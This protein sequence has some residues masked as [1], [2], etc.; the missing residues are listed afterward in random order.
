M[1][2]RVDGG[3]GKF[4][5]PTCEETIFDSCAGVVLLEEKVRVISPSEK[6]TKPHADPGAIVFRLLV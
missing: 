1:Y 6:V 2:G 4:V 5:N 3:T